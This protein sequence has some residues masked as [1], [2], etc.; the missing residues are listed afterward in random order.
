MRQA[1]STAVISMMRAMN[2]VLT[3]SGARYGRSVA[4]SAGV[5]AV[6]ALSGLAG[7][8]GCGDRDSDVVEMPYCEETKTPITDLS[9]ATALG[10]SAADLI[11]LGT[12]DFTDTMSW[13]DGSTSP[14]ALSVV[15][16]D[17]VWVESVAV[18]PESDGSTELIG[19]ECLPRVEVAVTVSVSTEDGRLAEVGGAAFSGALSSMAVGSASMTVPVDALAG[20]LDLASFAPEDG[21]TDM[22]ASFSYDVASD[23]T[24]SGSI[25][26]MYEYVEECPET[27]DCTASASM[28]EIGR[29]GGE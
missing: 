20:T 1:Q 6:L 11:A 16:G 19:V 8:T 23:G 7:L 18:Y 12:G 2:G 21:Y 27:D 3:A 22:S 24:T 26:A 4:R 15:A 13:V 5:G 29:W 14:L 10:F 9:A 17:A 25:S 28:V